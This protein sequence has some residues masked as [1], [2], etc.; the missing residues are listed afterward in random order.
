MPGEMNIKSR[1]VPWLAC[2][3]ASLCASRAMAGPVSYEGGWML[4]TENQ[5]DFLG[6]QLSYSLRPWFSLGVDYAYDAMTGAK[7]VP[8]PA[9]RQSLLPRANFLLHR[10]NERDSQANIYLYGGAGAAWRTGDEAHLAGLGGIEA[11][12]ESRQLYVSARAQA[13]AATGF[14]RQTL[15]Q[16]RAGLAP[17]LT[18]FEGLHSWLILQLQVLPEA[19][20]ERVRV[21][22]LMRFYIQNVLWELG[23]SARGTWTFNTMIHF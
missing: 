4:S 13:L 3:L 20:R 11:D 22:P 1:F 19:E 14:E 9:A 10:W 5:S 17:Y 16:A 8:P 18:G 6:W 21:T 2:V 15:W 7:A 23:V 12:W